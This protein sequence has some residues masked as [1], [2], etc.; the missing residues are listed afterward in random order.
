MEAVDA[1]TFPLSQDSAG[2]IW[3]VLDD[4]APPVI[5][6][7]ETQAGGQLFAYNTASGS[8][9]V[10]IKVPEEGT[11]A[12]AAI[13]WGKHLVVPVAS[14]KVELLDPATGKRAAL[15]FQ[16][17]LSPDSLPPWTRPTLT[18]DG[19]GIVIADG[20]GSLFRLTIKDQPQPHLAAAAEQSVA[21]ELYGALALAGDTIYALGR[22]DAGE[23][24]VAID[25]QSLEIGRQRWPL[26]GKPQFDPQ[27]VG[28]SVFVATDADG[29]LCL[30]GGEKLRWQRPLTHGPLSGP[31][32]AGPQ[33]ELLLLH[34][35]GVL[36]RISAA[37]GEETAA[38]NLGEPLGRVAG[39]LGEQVFVSTSDG[40][41]L[42]VPLPK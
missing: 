20:R 30:E 24:L 22:S 3:P 21:V 17:P 33:G 28:G 31:P 40:G 7:T 27:A 19:S 25:P 37:T 10:G 11:A 18:P 9:P 32:A 6:W 4:P 5:A 12:A 15:P 16:P 38:S 29:L 35:S 2:S 41:V 13:V 42:V 36:S 23:A 34:Q 14:G 1:A 26:V 8:A 39:L